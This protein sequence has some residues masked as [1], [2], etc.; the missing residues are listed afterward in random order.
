MV[1]VWFRELPSFQTRKLT[2][3]NSMFGAF[4][5]DITVVANDVIMQRTQRCQGLCDPRQLNPYVVIW[6]A[7]DLRA[8]EASQHVIRLSHTWRMHLL[9]ALRF[10]KNLVLIS[11]WRKDDGE[12]L[13]LHNGVSRSWNDNILW[14]LKRSQVNEATLEQQSPPFACLSDIWLLPFQ[15]YPSQSSSL[16]HLLF[17]SWSVLESI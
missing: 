7:R 4:S 8:L 6:L 14:W 15:R 10:N 11:S 1:K 13:H 12:I 16:Y 9:Q 5:C 17:H 2:Y 3:E